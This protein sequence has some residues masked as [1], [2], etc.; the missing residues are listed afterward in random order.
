MS[1]MSRRNPT[2]PSKRYVLPTSYEDDD[3]RVFKDV[4]PAEALY[5][6]YLAFGSPYRRIPLTREDMGLFIELMNTCYEALPAEVPPSRLFVRI[7]SK[8]TTYPNLE[9]RRHTELYATHFDAVELTRMMFKFK[10]EDE[11]RPVIR[12]RDFPLADSRNINQYLDGVVIKAMV[13]ME[14]IEGDRHR[15]S[16]PWEDDLVAAGWIR[17]AYQGE[18][19]YAPPSWVPDTFG[20]KQRCPVCV[21]QHPRPQACEHTSVGRPILSYFTR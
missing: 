17:N 21:V 2:P 6:E 1:A 15:G 5:N 7:T 8:R 20:F 11:A 10:R 12:F 4:D 19:S 9:G 18:R 14:D 13:F 16:A 3:G